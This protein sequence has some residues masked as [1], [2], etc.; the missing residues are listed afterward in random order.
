MI[1]DVIKKSE[2]KDV[3]KRQLVNSPIFCLYKNIRILL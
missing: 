1:K 3:Y 2:E